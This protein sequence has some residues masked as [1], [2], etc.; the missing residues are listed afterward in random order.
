MYIYK[1][2]YIDE[3]A[4]THTN[5]HT[6]TRAHTHT[7]AHTRA[8]AQTQTQTRTCARTR[9]RTRTHAHSRTCTHTHEHTSTRANKQTT[10]CM[11]FFRAAH[12][13]E[14]HVKSSTPA[15]HRPIK[16]RAGPPTP[17]ATTHACP[18][19][20]LKRRPR[21]VVTCRMPHAGCPCHELPSQ[22][23][24]ESRKVAKLPS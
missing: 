16:E 24:H 8:H 23:R 22:W 19:Q 17:Q 9:A 1:Y 13:I 11:F 7:H 4:R 2:K 14:S 20:P 15:R 6:H 21:T 5:A 10:C 3:Y 18:P 12:E